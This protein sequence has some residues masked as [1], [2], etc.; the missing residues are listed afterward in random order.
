MFHIKIIGTSAGRISRRPF[1]SLR[2]PKTCSVLLFQRR[3]VY[4]IDRYTSV[5]LLKKEPSLLL[6]IALRKISFSVVF[7]L[8]AVSLRKY[9]LSQPYLDHF[10]DIEIELV[11]RQGYGFSVATLSCLK[12]DYIGTFLGY[13]FRAPVTPY[14]NNL[15]I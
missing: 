7:I 11:G 12:T 6:S 1:H 2:P 4:Q 13:P 3:P 8:S 9:T 14:M 10:L 15:S 5:G